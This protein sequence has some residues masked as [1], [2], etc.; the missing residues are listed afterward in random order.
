MPWCSIPDHNHP[1]VTASRPVGHVLQKFGRVGRVAIPFIPYETGSLRK[2]VRAVPIDAFGQ[3]RAVAHA[4]EPFTNWSSRVTQIKVAV[5]MRLVDIDHRHLAV[6]HLLVEQL[7]FPQEFFA[8][9]RIGF[10]QQFLAFFPRQ[11]SP[12]QH[13]AQRVSANALPELLLDPPPQLLQSPSAAGKTV[14]RR[15]RSVDGVDD[16][17]RILR[18]KKGRRPPLCRYVKAS[19]PCSL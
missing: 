3:T 12:T 7:Q 11:S 19:G 16:L 10:P 18:L 1:A 17:F 9:L 5:K 6:A 4:P 13:T 15:R 8:L 2:V 14:V